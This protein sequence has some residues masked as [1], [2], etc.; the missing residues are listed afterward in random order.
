MSVGRDRQYLSLS[1]SRIRKSVFM[2]TIALAIVIQDPEV[3]LL[4]LDK[5]RVYIAA[6]VDNSR[7]N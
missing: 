6:V 2:R 4:L 5:T 7:C 3:M 1:N